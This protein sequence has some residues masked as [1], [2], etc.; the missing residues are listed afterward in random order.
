[1]VTNYEICKY[2]E[3][4][5]FK[6]LLFLLATEVDS[7]KYIKFSSQFGASFILVTFIFIPV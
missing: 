5:I 4:L 1:M 2:C 6:T 3:K 7:L